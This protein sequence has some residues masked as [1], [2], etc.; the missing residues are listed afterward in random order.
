MP[1]FPEISLW[2]E[3]K[4]DTSDPALMCAFIYPN[5]SAPVYDLSKSGAN[6]LIFSLAY[7]TLA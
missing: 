1:D 7:I 6:V 2:D 5:A 3:G 4:L